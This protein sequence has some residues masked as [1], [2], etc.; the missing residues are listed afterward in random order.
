MFPQSDVQQ[1]KRLRPR[2]GKRKRK[3]L[4]HAGNVKRS[5]P[6]LKR[7]QGNV[8]NAR[9]RLKHMLPNAARSSATN[10][11]RNQR[12]P[13]ELGGVEE[14]L[15]RPHV[16][17]LLYLHHHELK[18]L[19]PLLLLFLPLEHTDLVHLVVPPEDGESAKRNLLLPCL[20]GL[21]LPPLSHLVTARRLN[22]GRMMMDSRLFRRRRCGN[23]GDSRARH[24]Y[25]ML[26]C[27]TMLFYHYMHLFLSNT[28]QMSVLIVGS[29]HAI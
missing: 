14:R 7:R 29:T 21:R 16:R 1:R 10:Q 24:R 26:A 3:P 17:P 5:V 6:K 9:L 20:L 18:V 27:H 25:C 15:L 8:L 11:Q 28:I 23:L 12:S 19:Y 13:K 4:K 2:N 22:R